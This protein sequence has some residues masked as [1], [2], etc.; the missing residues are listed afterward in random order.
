MLLLLN[1][2]DEKRR[3]ELTRQWRDNKLAELNFVGVVVS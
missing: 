1:D 3:D 2:S